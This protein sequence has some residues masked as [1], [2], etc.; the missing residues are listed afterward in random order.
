MSDDSR[1]Q[2]GPAMPDVDQAKTLAFTNEAGEQVDYEARVRLIDVPRSDEDRRPVGRM[3]VTS[4]VRLFD[5]SPDPARPVMAL[6]NGG[7]I[8]ASTALLLSGIGPKRAAFSD[9]LDAPLRDSYHLVDSPSSLLTDCDL[10]V[11]DAIGCGYGRYEA[12]VDVESK[13]TAREDA[14]QFAEAAARWMVL[15]GREASPLYILGESYG[16]VRAPLM[17]K[18]ML[19]LADTQIAPAGVV[20]M[21][22]TTNIQEVHDRLR[23]VVAPAS[24]LPLMAAVAWYHK[25]G[26]LD[27]KDWREAVDKAREYAYGPYLSALYA[28]SR[29]PQARREAVAAEL[30]RFTGVKAAAWL[31]NRL[32]IS[33]DRFRSMLLEDEGKVVG[34]YDARYAAPASPIYQVDPSDSRVG[35]VLAVCAHRFYN[36]LLGVDRA[37][38]RVE[39]PG[40]VWSSWDWSVGGP[41][42]SVPEGAKKSP[43]DE[44]DYAGALEYCL[45][46]VAGFRLMVANGCYDTITTVGASD[47]LIA[48]MDAPEGSVTQRIY[49]AGHMTYTDRE[50]GVALNHDLAAFVASSGSPR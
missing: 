35:P 16:T 22:T 25:R 41:S 46:Q 27:A 29:L 4:F 33:K 3:S 26:S 47:A 21:G 12:D 6:F 2:P 40:D 24:S 34:V 14:R 38:T 32:N 30:E 1:H 11:M 9:D 37:L 28:G 5:G 50:S 7:P 45:Q 36:D 18:A 31:K 44:F 8:V 10:I 48:S 42:D 23:S 43:F 13:Y 39:A 20:L 15:E 19:E 49:P 17:A